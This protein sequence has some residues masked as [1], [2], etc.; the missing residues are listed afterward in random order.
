M[1]ADRYIFRVGYVHMCSR[2]VCVFICAHVQFSPWGYSSIRGLLLYSHIHP[3]SLS[4]AYFHMHTYNFPRVGLLI[5]LRF[6]LY[7]Y[8][9]PLPFCC[10][11]LHVCTYNLPRMG[12]LIF[13]PHQGLLSR[14]VYIALSYI[15]THTLGPWSRLQLLRCHYEVAP[16][17]RLLKNIG[18][19]CKRAL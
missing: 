1:Y 15:H 17:S 14:S 9:Y 8:I 13:W 6:C 16:M 3:F 7:A 12:L 11:Y 18:L 4:C 5:N 19:F 2:F 10:A